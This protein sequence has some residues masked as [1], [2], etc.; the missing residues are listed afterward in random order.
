MNNAKQAA[1][2]K[3]KTPVKAIVEPIAKTPINN[4]ENIDNRFKLFVNK[5]WFNQNKLNTRLIT[6]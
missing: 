6:K 4:V 5:S 3:A 1:T 2:D